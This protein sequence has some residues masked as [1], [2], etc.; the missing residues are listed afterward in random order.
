MKSA[1]GKP[2]GNRSEKCDQQRQE[3]HK[4]EHVRY[5]DRSIEPASQQG[6]DQQQSQVDRRQYDRL[7]E[8][9]RPPEPAPR[10]PVAQ[11]SVDNDDECH[12]DGELQVAG[13]HARQHLGKAQAHQR[14]QDDLFEQRGIQ[15]LAG[16][17]GN[18]AAHLSRAECRLVG[19]G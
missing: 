14:D 11:C 6:I 8:R 12:P 4:E 1:S 3:K 17:A 16:L 18:G 2:A 10:Q 5:P 7:P 19:V 15:N 13:L 9:K